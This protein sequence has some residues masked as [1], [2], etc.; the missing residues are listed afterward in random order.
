MPPQPQHPSLS[1]ER[2]TSFFSVGLALFLIALACCSAGARTSSVNHDSSEIIVRGSHWARGIT[3]DIH[4]ILIVPPPARYDEWR[5][6]IADD[7]VVRLVTEGDRV[8]RPG[9][10]GWRLEA[11][12]RGETT[13]TFVPFVRSRQQSSEPNEPHF[14]LRVTVR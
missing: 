9:S 4:D 10:D 3:A 13:V 2:A 12:G 6:R 8:R 14:T 7:T 11:V 1:L 5:V